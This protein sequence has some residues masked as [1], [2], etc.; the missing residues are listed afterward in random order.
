MIAVVKMVRLWEIN[1]RI[2]NNRFLIRFKKNVEKKKRASCSKESVEF[3][4]TLLDWLEPK[5]YKYI[6]KKSE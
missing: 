2:G 5:E 1:K 4:E 6:K 3:Q